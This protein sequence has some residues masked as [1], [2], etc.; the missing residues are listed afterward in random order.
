MKLLWRW[1][2]LGLLLWDNSDLHLGD[3]QSMVSPAVSVTHRLGHSNMVSVFF[4]VKVAAMV[5]KSRETCNLCNQFMP[6]LFN[7]TIF[8]N[9]QNFL[10]FF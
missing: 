6:I 3:D 10:F 9:T 2:S 7:F 1:L 5:T 4:Q 8:S